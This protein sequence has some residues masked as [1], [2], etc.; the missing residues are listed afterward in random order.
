MCEF[1]KDTNCDVPLQNRSEGLIIEA[2]V[3]SKVAGNTTLIGL[4]S[5]G[6]FKTWVLDSLPTSSRLNLSLNLTSPT[7]YKDAKSGQLGLIS[8]YQVSW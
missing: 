4:S 8:E 7:E 3:S 5:T 6:Q 2:R 1:Y